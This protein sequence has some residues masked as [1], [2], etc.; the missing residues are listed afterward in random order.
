M[1]SSRVMQMSSTR[2]V[3]NV[4][5]SESVLDALSVSNDPRAAATLVATNS[6]VKIFSMP[7]WASGSSSSTLGVVEVAASG[8]PARRSPV[9]PPDAPACPPKLAVER[10]RLL[11]SPGVWLCTN[12]NI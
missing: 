10:R 7:F 3:P 9:Q 6:F 11:P 12:G 8:L 2:S 1:N 5:V 4:P